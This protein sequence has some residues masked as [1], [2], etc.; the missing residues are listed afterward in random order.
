MFHMFRLL[1]SMW[2]N[3]FGWSSPMLPLPGVP[4][5]QCYHCLPETKLKFDGYVW[6]SSISLTPR[7]CCCVAIASKIVN[8]R[9]QVPTLGRLKYSFTISD[10]KS[11]FLVISFVNFSKWYLCCLRSYEHAT[12]STKTNTPYRASVTYRCD[13]ASSIAEDSAF[14]TENE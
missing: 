9:R 8:E 5:K 2:C 13:K 6:T 3:G 11:L 14:T 10:Q 7:V 4:S 1:M 12:E